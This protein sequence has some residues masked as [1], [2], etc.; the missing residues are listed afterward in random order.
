MRSLHRRSNFLFFP[1]FGHESWLD[2]TKASPFFAS[3]RTADNGKKN[4]SSDAGSTVN[5]A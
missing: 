1:V 2:L 5:K 3:L 4:S